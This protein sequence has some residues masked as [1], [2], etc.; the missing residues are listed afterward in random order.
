[1]RKYEKVIVIGTASPA[2]KLAVLLTEHINSVSFIENFVNKEFVPIIYL[3]NPKLEW[4]F[5]LNK[6]WFDILINETNKTLCISISN[7]FILPKK[8]LSNKSITCINLHSALLPK[9]KGRNYGSWAIYNGERETGITWHYLTEEV[10]A[11]KII[12][13]DKIPILQNETSFMLF[14]R[15]NQ[16]GLDVFEKNIGNLL[17]EDI[18]GTIQDNKEKSY[19]YYAKDRPNNGVLDLTWNADK[20]DRFLRA[21]DWGPLYELGK[22]S[23]SLREKNYEILSYKIENTE[24]VQK[25]QIYFADE[26]N[27]VVKKENKIFSLNTQEIK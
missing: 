11:G 22:S 15:L 18:E 12:W 21:M 7:R 14:R 2:Y 24:T 25:E 17:S 13:Q 10:D 27:L 23:V 6:E 3:Q 9:Y 8:V 16:L 20:I 19:F 1:M 4:N 5:F 26:N